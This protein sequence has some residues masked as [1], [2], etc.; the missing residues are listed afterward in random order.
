LVSAA[1]LLSFFA[2][3]G[4]AAAAALASPLGAFSFLPPSVGDEAA[5]A[6]FGSAFAGAAFDSAL[7]ATAGAPSPSS[8]IS[9]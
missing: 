4:A 1:F 5:A 2:A 6:F 3:F 7:A 9:T 8:T